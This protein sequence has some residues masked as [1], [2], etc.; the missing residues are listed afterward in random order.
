MADLKALYSEKVLDHFQHPRNIGE[1]KD[2]DGVGTVGNPVCVI[3][4]T[5]VLA[6]SETVQ[7]KD[8]LEGK[9]V[10]GHDGFFHPVLKV[11]KRNY[12]GI[13]FKIRVH[14][15]GET[16]ITPEHHVLAL[17]MSPFSH[18]FEAFTRNKALLDWFNASQLAKGDVLLY[19]ILKENVNKEILDIS[20]KK[21]KW[22]FKSYNLPA[23]VLVNDN[24]LRLCG[25]YLAEG[26][27]SDRVT[28]KELGY[29]FGSHEKQL[30]DDTI[31]LMKE[32]FGFPPSCIREV[33]NSINIMYYRAQLVHLFRGLFGKGAVEKHIPH[34]MMLLPPEKQKHLLCG[35]W[36]GDGYIS[37]K[38]KTS[39]FVTVSLEL[40]HQ[41]RTLL[42]RQ[43]IIFSF[44]N[45]PAKGIHKKHYSLYVKE[46]SSLK[47]LA[48][49]VGKEINFP[50]NK[51]SPHKT[52][53]D[54]NYY[55]AP[56]WKVEKVKYN[57]MVH[58]LEVKESASYVVSGATLHNC[59]DVMRLFLKIKT[60]N[61]KGKKVEYVEDA[62]FQTLGCGAAIATSSIATEM[63]KGKPLSEAMELTN[64]AITEA[65]GGLPPVKRHCSVLAADAVKKA[66]A[67]YESKRK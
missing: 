55:Y 42:F 6:N 28:R 37:Q 60:K 46:D 30:I 11:F 1:M 14:N 43:K 33:H 53:F 17:K 57:G 54:D 51:K 44:L 40:A 52:W 35:L 50:S 67:D 12:K 8:V 27:L 23:K 63:I 25:Y 18:K 62:K 47:K 45:G 9:R 39:K 20:L 24:F 32:I 7:I 31:F 34:W 15:L 49:I 64:Q 10:L 19:P 61:E 2:P 58:N 26:Y 4:E 65:L 48:E 38:S 41:V 13:L 36:R 22:D 16:V 56:I 3:P 5:L 59:G 66:I 29:V 21:S